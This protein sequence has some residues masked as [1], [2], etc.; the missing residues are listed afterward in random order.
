MELGVW[1]FC[2]LSPIENSKK[3]HFLKES[4]SVFLATPAAVAWFLLL[5][6]AEMMDFQHYAG[7][8]VSLIGRTLFPKAH[9][10]MRRSELWSLSLSLIIAVLLCA[11]FG[12]LLVVLNK[13]GRP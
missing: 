11:A 12:V 2:R 5:R 3:L 10:T 6:T 9:R 8:V 13:E 4:P 1:S 7:S